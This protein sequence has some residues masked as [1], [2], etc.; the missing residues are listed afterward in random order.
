MDWLEQ[1]FTEY[2]DWL[3]TAFGGVG[4]AVIAWVFGF[5][6]W[7]WKRLRGRPVPALTVETDGIA[8]QLA[9]T[10]KQLGAAEQREIYREELRGKDE[11]IQELEKAVEAL[12]KQAG[13]PDAPPGID[14][15]LK[16]LAQGETESAEAIFEQVLERKKGEAAS[17]EAAAAARHI[18]ALAFL[19]DT[20]K[21]LSAYTEAIDLDPEDPDG[22]NML[23]ALQKRL[24]NL[25]AATK[26]FERVLALGN[27][28]RDKAVIAVA[29]GNLGIVYGTRGDLAKAEEYH[30]K[31]LAIEEELG[32][33][34]GMASDY[35][36]LGNVYRAR[37]DLAKAEEYHLKS[38]AIEEELGRKEG[39]ANAY[40]NLGLVFQTRGDLA[41][42]EEY[43]LKSL[44][45]EEELG[46]KEGMAD[47]YGNL[48]LVYEER[49]DL[50]KAEEHHLKSLAL[51]EVLGNKVSMAR[52]YD[53]LG[54]IYA[55]RDDLVRGEEMLKKGL[56]MNRSMGDKQGIAFSLNNL[57][58]LNKELGNYE[59]AREM[60]QASLELFK[61][62]RSTGMVEHTERAIKDLKVS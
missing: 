49:G 26:A 20:Q 10:A 14:A 55:E 13:A 60:L 41:K 48:G 19:H 21:A 22:W 16:Q 44:A 29:Y 40:G 37:G 59:F 11:Q 35:G 8:R 53:L 51:N 3:L 5:F 18:G 32:R 47:A 9:K 4:V 7:L 38:L 30:L 1:F 17:K 2:K 23:G 57:G 25:D 33:K 15:A 27:K 6:R 31:A 61:D 58:T 62:L 56:E 28:V 34:E 36:N 42:A 24:G 12:K 45:I 46:R 52:N 54:A 39:M 43:H 50:A